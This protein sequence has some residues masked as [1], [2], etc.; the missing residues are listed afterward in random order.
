V[1]GAKIVAARERSF[2][3]GGTATVARNR[4]RTNGEDDTT[5]L[6]P[7]EKQSL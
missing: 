5:W 2:A 1:I 4:R 3:H 7:R 6:Y